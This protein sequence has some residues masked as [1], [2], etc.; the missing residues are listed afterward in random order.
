M[1]DKIS[2]TLP[3][4][5]DDSAGMHVFTLPPLLLVMPVMNHL[6]LDP[7]TNPIEAILCKLAELQD[8]IE[9]I[10][11]TACPARLDHGSMVVGRVERTWP[12]PPPRNRNADAVDLP[13]CAY[14]GLIGLT[15]R[16]ID[17]PD[18]RRVRVLLKNDKYVA[19]VNFGPFYHNQEVSHTAL[20]FEERGGNMI[21]EPAVVSNPA[22][23][24]PRGTTINM[25]I[26]KV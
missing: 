3:G 11:E 23:V 10:E 2:G 26:G 14:V 5:N 1:S 22:A 25:T 7:R 15:G 9:H 6:G 18:Y 12:Q 16:E 4:M 8:R 19:T 24:V 13:W 20:F 21:G 17:D